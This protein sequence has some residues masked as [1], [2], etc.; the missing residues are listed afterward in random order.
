VQHGNAGGYKLSLVD[1][2]DKPIAAGSV[3]TSASRFV[4]A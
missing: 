4:L 3:C 2:K 1:K